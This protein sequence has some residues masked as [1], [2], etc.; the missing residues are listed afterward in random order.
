[1]NTTNDPAF[2]LMEF[3]YGWCK[4]EEISFFGKTI[5]VEVLAEAEIGQPILDLQRNFYKSFCSELEPLSSAALAALKK[6]YIENLPAIGVQ[7]DDAAE[8]PEEEEL[9][10][11]DLI[12]MV[13]P[14]VIFFPQDELYA[15]LCDCIWEPINGLAI[16]ISDDGIEI[17]TQ[18]EIL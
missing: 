2:G 10:S 8:L 6:Y 5:S 17:G 4:T 3:N 16:I 9:T 7:V 14:K 15:V 12:K 18:D 11:A 1:M 13:K